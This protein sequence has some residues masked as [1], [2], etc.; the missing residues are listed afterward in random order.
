AQD[1]GRRDHILPG[2]KEFVA[3]DRLPKPSG[4]GGGGGSGK[5]P[6]GSGGGD[7][8][9]RFVLSREEFLDLFFEDLELPDLIK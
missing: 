4:Q 9:F 3:G 7:D 6:A 1:S 2:N 8:D 5:G